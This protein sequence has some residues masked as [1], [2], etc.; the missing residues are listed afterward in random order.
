MYPA[1]KRSHSSNASLASSSLDLKE[2]THTLQDLNTHF[3]RTTKILTEIKEQLIKVGEKQETR[4]VDDNSGIHKLERVGVP[5]SLSLPFLA[6]HVLLLPLQMTVELRFV[7]LKIGEIDTLKEQF[8]AEA[9][10][11]AR[12]FEPTLKG[13]VSRSFATDTESN[14]VSEGSRWIRSE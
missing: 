14:S 4:P 8:Q 3:K 2:F 11:Q 1:A 7:F 6:I 13:T 9:F 10:I 5:S 12:W